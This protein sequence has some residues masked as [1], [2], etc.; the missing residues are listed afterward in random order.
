MKIFQKIHFQFQRGNA[1]FSSSLDWESNS[2]DFCKR[3][4]CKEED[5][6]K[7]GLTSIE[8]YFIIGQRLAISIKLKTMKVFFTLIENSYFRNFHLPE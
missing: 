2:S 8:Q 4:N 7:K 3:K 5:D 1:R 6:R